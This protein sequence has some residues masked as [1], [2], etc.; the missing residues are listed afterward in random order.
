MIIRDIV[1]KIEQYAPLD[2]SYNL[3]A[4]GDYDNS[5]FLIGDKNVEADGV[6]V[7]VDVC[8]DAID[9]ALEKGCNLIISHHPFIYSPISSVTED[10]YKGRLIRRLV[11]NGISVYSSH[12]PMDMTFGGIDDRFSEYFGE[13]LLSKMIDEKSYS[14]G[15]VVSIEEKTVGELIKSLK[16]DFSSVRC[17]GDKE[18]TVS[19]IASF[20]GKASGSDVRFAI[21]EHADLF[22]SCDIDHQHLVELN[23]NGISV[24]ALNHGESEYYFFKR[25][26]ESLDLG[27]EKY[28]CKTDFRLI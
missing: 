25:I 12:L 1:S 20:C 15:K 8:N 6:V 27:V 2:I 5:G 10:D 28:Y 4:K 9:L 11:Q 7:T 21:K 16:K 26:F 23:E 18:K 17:F 24:I 13:T 14:Y 22:V 3:I 19:K